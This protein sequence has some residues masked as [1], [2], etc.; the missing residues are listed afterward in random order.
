MLD[1][2]PAQVADVNQSLY[3]VLEL[4]EDTE[5]GDIAYDSLVLAAYRILLADVL[6]RVLGKLLESEGNLAGLTVD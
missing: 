4:S 1:L 5:V 3:A 2:V 6:P